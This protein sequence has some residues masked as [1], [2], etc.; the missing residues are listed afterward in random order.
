MLTFQLVFEFRNL[1]HTSFSDLVYVICMPF[2][3][4]SQVKQKLFNA[5]VFVDDLISKIVKL[6]Q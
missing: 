4:S 1:F 2:R 3:N 5:T 6:F